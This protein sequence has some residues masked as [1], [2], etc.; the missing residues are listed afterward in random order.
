MESPA[1]GEPGPV[2]CHS[3]MAAADESSGPTA[4]VNVSDSPV[5]PDQNM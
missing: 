1:D 4:I 3:T 2:Q 5:K